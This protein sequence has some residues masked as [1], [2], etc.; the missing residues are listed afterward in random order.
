[1]LLSNCKHSV[2]KLIYLIW[3]RSLKLG[4]VPSGYK[5]SIITPLHKKDS[6]AII[7]SNYRPV[8]L[9]SH[10]IRIY[11]RVILIRIKLVTYLESNNLLCSHQHGFRS[12]H[13][14]LTQLLHHID[15][16]LHYYLSGA[17][18]DSIYLD[19][20]KAFN[21]VDHALLIRKLE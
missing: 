15:D 13:S 8:S 3:S 11:E 5:S 4:V 20:A 2:A 17:D 9:T 7:S 19:Y 10:V 1:M 6:R 16:V 18:T 12:G 14:C 21:K